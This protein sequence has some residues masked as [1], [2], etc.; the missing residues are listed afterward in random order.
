MRRRRTKEEEVVRV[1]NEEVKE[2]GK[3][4]EAEQD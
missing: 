3:E 1:K 2:E 4:K